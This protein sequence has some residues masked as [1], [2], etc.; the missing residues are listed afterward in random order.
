MTL[1]QHFNVQHI[2]MA[3]RAT[4]AIVPTVLVTFCPQTKWHDAGQLDL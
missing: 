1:D 4:K 3:F 2:R